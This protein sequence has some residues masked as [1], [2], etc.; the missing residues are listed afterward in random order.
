VYL[1]R[2]AV[3]RVCRISRACRPAQS[4]TMGLAAADGAERGAMP[5]FWPVSVQ[6]VA[7][8]AAGAAGGGGILL[9]A[10]LASSVGFASG[11]EAGN[12]KRARDGADPRDRFAA[13]VCTWSFSQQVVDVGS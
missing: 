8:M 3:A 11:A 4:F 6:G 2:D 12:N 13:P 7:D 10:Q 1:I 9:N 5:A